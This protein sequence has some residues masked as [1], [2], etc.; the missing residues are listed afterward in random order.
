MNSLPI[1]LKNPKILLIGG[2]PVA[3]QKATV[4]ENNSIDFKVI[5]KEYCEAFN[6]LHVKQIIKDFE[7][8]DTHGF[9]YVVD[10]T[11]DDKVK[12]T[13]LENKNFLLNIVDVPEFCDF[14][15]SSLLNYGKLKIAISS[16]GSSPTATQVVRDEIKRI[17]PED[18]DE[19]CQK[20]AIQRAIGKIDKTLAKTECKKY[21]PSIYLIGC[22]LGDAELLTIKAYKA[23]QIIDVALYD[24]LITEEILELLPVHVKKVFVG[25][26]KGAHSKSQEEINE[27]ILFYAKQGL[28][29][30]RLKSGDPYIFG[31]GAE[32]AKELIEE[33]YKVEVINGLTSAI[34]GV[35]QAGIPVT[36]R[37]YA[38]NFSVV[39]AHLKGSLI[40]LDW[41]HLLSVKNHTTVV[42]M[43]LSLCKHIQKEA[44][45]IGVCNDMEVAIVSNASRKNQ[46][47]KVTTLAN[48]YKDSLEMVSPAVLVFGKVVRL[49]DKLI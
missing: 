26:Q 43:G 27:L 24:N 36:A 47:V 32:E 28:K 42:L 5:S 9:N 21:F 8:K 49:S 4:L 12:Q 13:L 3:L 34:A 30:G 20:Q 11:G 17:I 18:I 23:M 2:G 39:S 22:G 1:L 16:D 37:D 6:S 15:F 29:V 38:T 10:A 44:F 19:F 31:R 14:Y 41:I 25:K 33:G 35:A 7:I 48:L 40:N 45:K 46:K